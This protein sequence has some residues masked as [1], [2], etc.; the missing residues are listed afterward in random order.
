M[1]KKDLLL[2]IMN[3]ADHHQTKKV[4]GLM[5]NERGGK[6]MTEFAI[7]SHKKGTKKVCSKKKT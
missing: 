2:Q 5:K 6:I 1:L 7:L 4:S 3:Y